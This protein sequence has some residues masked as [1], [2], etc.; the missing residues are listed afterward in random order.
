MDGLLLSVSHR[1]LPGTVL[2]S[3]GRARTRVSEEPKGRNIEKHANK[4]KH[5]LSGAHPALA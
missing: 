3:G 5:E 1:G 2:G 4:R